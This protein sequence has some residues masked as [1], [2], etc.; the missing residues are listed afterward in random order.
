MRSAVA[1]AMAVASL[2][3]AGSTLRAQPAPS[4]DP[5]I[6]SKGY[7]WNAAIAEKTEALELAGNVENGERVYR[8]CSA[9]HLPSGAGLPD[10]TMPQL[11]GQHTTVLIKQ[12]TDIRAGVRDNPIMHPYAANLA[13]ARELAD[14][15]AYIQALPVP[16]D[17]GTG[18]GSDL[19]RGRELYERDC[20]RCHGRRGEGIAEM[21]Y[22]VLS[23]QHYRYLL[24][25]LIDIAWGRRRNAYPEMVA[26]V[27]G[28]SAEEFSLVS[29]YASRLGR[30]EPRPEE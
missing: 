23:R 24:R 11:A 26:V 14:V 12:M 18:P 28:Y 1:L 21:F 16:I 25:Q 30:N 13:D 10:G 15:A 2:T 20:A 7:V 8:T 19:E 22:P 17:N 3:V 5:G 29:D 9:C 27:E 4:S 6:E